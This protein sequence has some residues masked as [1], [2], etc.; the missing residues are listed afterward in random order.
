MTESVA[1]ISVHDAVAALKDQLVADRRHFHQH[2]ECGFQERE[3]AAYVADRLTK[4]GIEHQTGVAQ[5]G[6]VGLIRGTHPG[7]C[8]LLRADMDA[9]P[10]TEETGAEYASQTP[11]VHHACGH[12]GHTAMLLAAAEIL[13]QLRD[14][15]HGTVKLVFQPAEEGPGGAKPMIEAGVMEDP[16]VD[17]CFG[18]HLSNDNAIGTLVVQGG[19]LQ[20]SADTF[21]ITVTGIGGHGA[22][23]HQTVDTVAV[24][25]AIIGELQRII[26]REVDPRDPAVITVGAFHGGTAPNIIPQ[27]AE[28]RGTIRTLDPAVQEFVHRRMRE[29][30]EGIAS[31]ARA[32]ADVRISP[33]YPVTVN[34]ESMAD[35]ARSIVEQVPN[36]RVVRQ[37]RPIMGAE[38][39]SFFLNAAPGCFIFVGSANHERGLDHPH[40]GPLFDFDEAALPIGVE[41]H[42]RLTLAY[43][44]APQDTAATDGR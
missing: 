24:G 3:T 10:L 6:V 43:L 36:V 19:P 32:T 42:C 15:I 30:A 16:Q 5:T 38:D 14:Q 40:H 34:D 20:A 29:V 18:L 26:S 37:Q 22:S 12:D 9:L 28:L 25:A 4:L 7:R 17:A 33:L 44:A 41:V 35:F 27:R 2:P 8:V 1:S 13:Q 23:P 21:E 39:M 11:G 31:A